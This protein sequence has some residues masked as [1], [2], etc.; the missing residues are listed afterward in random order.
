MPGRRSLLN[1]AVSITNNSL[2]ILLTF[3]FL[4]HCNTMDVFNTC[5]W[6]GKIYRYKR[7]IISR[8]IIN[9]KYCSE[10]C[11]KQAEGAVKASRRLH[12]SNSLVEIRIPP[13]MCFEEVE[14][15]R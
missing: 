7:G 15:V 14:D 2:P 6:C 11:K 3:H 9:R 10:T 13:I 4:A 8:L 12:R 1:I 5:N